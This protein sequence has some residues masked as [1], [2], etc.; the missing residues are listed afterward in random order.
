ML[1]EI[2]NASGQRLDYTYHPGAEG[3]RDLVLIGHGVTANKDRPFLVAL[4]EGLA[5]AGIP[6]LRLSFSGN[7][8][9]EG[10]F[11][12]SCV[13]REVD[14][15]AC[16]LSAAEGRRLAYVGHSMGGAV[17]VLAAARDE[18]IRLLVS[19]AGMVKTAEF[20]QRKFGE[21]VPGRDRMWDK[22][23][24][25]LSQAFLDD[26]AAIDSVEDRIEDVRVPWL[27]VHGTADEVVLPRDSHLALE[28]S[29]GRA[30]LVE[31]PG[32]DHV[33]SGEAASAMVR[34]VVPWLI[35][36]LEGTPG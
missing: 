36:R 14:D 13:S 32:A 34:A 8:D 15:L 7:G 1:G 35:V 21:L 5:A 16:F 17:G 24:C 28:R 27:L 31:L 29:R 9:S 6:A 26:M 2:Q 4:A 33:F 3:S 20:A 10:R 25:P 19:L 11:E 23:E 12:D 22:P 30:E 18:R